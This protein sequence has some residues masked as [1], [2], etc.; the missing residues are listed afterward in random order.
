M[1]TDDLRNARII[2]ITL[3]SRFDLWGYLQLSRPIGGALVPIKMA[4]IW[5]IVLQQ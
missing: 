1:L 2:M 5:W 4:A 3:A